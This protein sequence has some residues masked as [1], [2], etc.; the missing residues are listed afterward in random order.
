[1]KIWQIVTVENLVVASAYFGISYNIV[2]GLTVAKYQLDRGKDEDSREAIETTLR[3][4]R[5]LITELLGERESELELGPGDL[6]RSAS[7]TVTS[8]RRSGA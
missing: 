1:M 2:Q 8:E 3:K 4:A 7:A 6:R 5:G